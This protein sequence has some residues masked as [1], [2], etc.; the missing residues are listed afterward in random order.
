[1]HIKKRLATNT[2]I[3]ELFEYLEDFMWEDSLKY[4]D[5]IG[6]SDV[7]AG[8]EKTRNSNM[9]FLESLYGRNIIVGEIPERDAKMF[10]LNVISY[11]H[12][13][14]GSDSIEFYADTYIAISGNYERLHPDHDYFNFEHETRRSRAGRPKRP[15]DDSIIKVHHIAKALDEG[16]KIN[17]VCE[18]VGLAKST[19]YRVSKWL[20]DNRVPKRENQ[21]V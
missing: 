17:Q 19:Y 11:Y 10:F 6:E 4:A 20:K 8:R 7:T 14:E 13:K 1:M 2:E 12:E 9:G 5:T 3:D 16:G 15:S 21:I 18:Q